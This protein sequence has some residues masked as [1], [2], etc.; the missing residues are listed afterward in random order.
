[1][2]DIADQIINGECCDMC[3]VPFDGIRGEPTTCSTCAIEDVVADVKSAR[4]NCPLCNKR[5]KAI[6]ILN[7]IE[8]THPL[9]LGPAIYS[10][11]SSL[12]K[13]KAES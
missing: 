10:L 4:T 7:H 5:I 3:C 12:N 11:I 9:K 8:S 1:M 2:G 6:G 13:D